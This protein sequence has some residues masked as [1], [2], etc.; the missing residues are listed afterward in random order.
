MEPTETANEMVA[1]A[2]VES[3]SP[4]LAPARPEASVRPAQAAAP[5]PTC[6]A[7]AA[8]AMAGSSYVY[9]LGQIEERYPRPS[10]E[11]EVA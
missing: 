6:G 9:V 11:K 2:P 3:T 8:A 10:V 1:A 4:I 7:G 5:C